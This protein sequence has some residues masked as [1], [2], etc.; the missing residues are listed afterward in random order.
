MKKVFLGITLLI[1]FILGFSA[2]EILV[3]KVQT[4]A[5]RTEPRF[6]AS[7]KS[8][9]TFGDQMEKVGFQEGWYQVKT[10]RGVSGWVHSSAVQPR[11]SKLAALTQGPRA[12]PTASE[13]ALA[14]KGFNRQVESAYRKRHPEIDYSWV[15][16]MLSFKADQAAIEKFLRE[17]RLGEWKE[18]K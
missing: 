4:T 1:V 10:L 3:I 17:G 8:L 13:V 12:Q 2:S 16:R 18:V 7:V 15:D 6:F 5:L 14:S 9:L 11:P